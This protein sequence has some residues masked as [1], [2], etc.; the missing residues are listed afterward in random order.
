MRCA[1]LNFQAFN[2]TYNVTNGLS[3][4]L[5]VTCNGVT[6]TYTLSQGQY[7]ATSLVSTLNSTTT[8]V[9]WSYSSATNKLTLTSSYAFSL[10]SGSTML[11]T[12]GFSSGTAYTASLSGSS[13][14]LTSVNALN[15][16]GTRYFDIVTSLITHNVSNSDE[17]GGTSHVPCASTDP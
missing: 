12:L 16:G 10:G 15:L 13:Y 4:T 3:D 5:V 7:S 2:L 17:E 9:T 11:A 6:S 8:N 1:V 14:K